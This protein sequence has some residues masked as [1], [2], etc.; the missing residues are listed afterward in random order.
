MIYGAGM[1][2]NDYILSFIQPDLAQLAAVEAEVEARNDIQP[3]VGPQV[4]RLLALLVRLTRAQR[5]LELGTCLGYSS[6]WLAAALKETGGQLV[7]VEYRHDLWQQTHDNL[8]AAG[9]LDRVDLREGDA[10]VIVPALD[11]PFDLILQ[12]SAKGLYPQLLEDCIRLVR[13]YG[14]IA[15]DDTMF[16]P[17]GIPDS[18]ARPMDEY[19]RL[20]FADPRLYS[21]ILP[22]GDGL[23]LSVKVGGF[24]A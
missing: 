22:I 12:D 24:A 10:A 2:D 20:V 14:V 4:G 21:T 1:N 11:A 18:F 3:A 15:A 23:T 17:R 9:L 16:L 19:N 8:A 7:S 5:V 13:P 6:L